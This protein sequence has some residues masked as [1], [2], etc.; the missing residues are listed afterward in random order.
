LDA[1]YLKP[2]RPA[3]RALQVLAWLPVVLLAFGLLLFFEVLRPFRD[4]NIDLPIALGGWALGL[5]IALISIWKRAGNLWLNIATASCNFLAFLGLS[6]LVSASHITR[7][8]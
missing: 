6:L 2:R 5:V 8:M 7:L 4:L 1:I 3:S